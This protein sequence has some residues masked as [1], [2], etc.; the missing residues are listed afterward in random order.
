MPTEP[1]FGEMWE[2]GV[3]RMMFV[4]RGA[5]DSATTYWIFLETK[6]DYTGKWVPARL[7]KEPRPL[8]SFDFSPEWKKVEA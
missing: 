2:L 7:P 5:H 4:G 3:W 6:D 1:R 8:A